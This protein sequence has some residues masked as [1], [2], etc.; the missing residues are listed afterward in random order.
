MIWVSN[1][2]IE[3]IVNVPAQWVQLRQIRRFRPFPGY[4]QSP[5]VEMEKF[6]CTAKLSKQSI[7]HVYRQ[8]FGFFNYMIHQT[9][10]C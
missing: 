9:Y 4:F 6:E 8:T 10:H 1:G 3:M 2:N 5:P 7:T